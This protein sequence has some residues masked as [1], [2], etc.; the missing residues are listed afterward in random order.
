AAARLLAGRPESFEQVVLGIQLLA[1][2]PGGVPGVLRVRAG[3]L[4]PE[5][6]TPLTLSA[7]AQ[8][9][10]VVSF[11]L[12]DHTYALHYTIDDVLAGVTRNG[13]AFEL[14]DLTTARIRTTAGDTWQVGDRTF[15]RLHGQPRV[16]VLGSKH[17]VVDPSDQRGHKWDAVYTEAPDADHRVDIKVRLE[18][19]GT[20][21]LLV[22]ASTGTSGFTGLMLRLACETHCTA[23]LVQFNEGGSP[24][25]L[26]RAVALPLA[27]MAGY[28]VRFEVQGDQVT[29]QIASR[30]LRATLRE[31]LTP[32][33]VGWVVG[34]GSRVFLRD[35][36]ITRS[37]PST[38]P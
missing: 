20:G 21:G 35:W 4:G 1:T 18:G 12:E 3:R 17:M 14:S 37:E 38:Q 34:T 7:A 9:R 2:A 30:T 13:G 5:G 8:D 25:D 28:A 31:P 32:G 27:P 22:G 16:G 24:Q 23:Q 26:S 6:V 29:A 11:E 15:V 10:R 36:E 33:H 19:H